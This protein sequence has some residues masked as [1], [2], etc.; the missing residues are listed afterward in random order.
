MV[1]YRHKRCLEGKI[2][3]THAQHSFL[4]DCF[5]SPDACIIEKQER[6]I[7]LNSASSFF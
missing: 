5:V 2:S 6:C 3:T 1:Y 7:F 4:N